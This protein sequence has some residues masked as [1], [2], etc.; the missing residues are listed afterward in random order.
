[1]DRIL[2]GIMNY[3]NTKMKEMVQEFQ[4]VRDNPQVF[5]FSFH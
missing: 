4:K 1:M 5:P 3:R 2:R